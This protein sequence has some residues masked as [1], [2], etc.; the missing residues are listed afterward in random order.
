MK[1]TYI[2]LSLVCALGGTAAVPVHAAEPCK[3][4]SEQACE[5]S[6]S[7]RWVNGYVRKDGREVGAYCRASPAAKSATKAK[8]AAAG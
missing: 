6:T 2:T 5:A 4:L 1:A 8:A 7:C 3:G